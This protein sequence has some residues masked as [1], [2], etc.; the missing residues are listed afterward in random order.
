MAHYHVKDSFVIEEYIAAKEKILEADKKKKAIAEGKC[1][2]LDVEWGDLKV[3]FPKQ[4][5]QL[6]AGKKPLIS[7]VPEP[8][9]FMWD[10][11]AQ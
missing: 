6:M 7:K 4:F 5:E 1:P 8:G 9:Y 2:G 11:T 10:N 3:K